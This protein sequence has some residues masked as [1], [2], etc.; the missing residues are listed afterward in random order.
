MSTLPH[1]EGGV[2][3]LMDMFIEVEDD[4]PTPFLKSVGNFA[5]ASLVGG[6]TLGGVGILLAQGIFG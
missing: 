2:S 5:L 3:E 1:N 6:L 4:T